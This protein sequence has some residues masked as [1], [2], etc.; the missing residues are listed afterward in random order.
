[1]QADAVGP[2]EDFRLTIKRISDDLD[3]DEVLTLKYLCNDNI[4]NKRLEEIKTG[5]DL[6]DVLCN[7]NLV[8][9]ED[10]K[11]LAECLYTIRRADLLRSH[12][13]LTFSDVKQ[14]MSSSG[15]LLDP[16]RVMI[17][18]VIECMGSSEVKEL[19]FCL[20]EYLPKKYTKY[21]S[22]YTLLM[23]LE[24]CGQL[25]PDNLDMLEH[26]VEKTVEDES[27]LLDIRE[28]KAKRRLMNSQQQVDPTTALKLVIRP[29]EPPLVK[30]IETTSPQKLV[31][32]PPTQPRRVEVQ[33][34]TGAGENGGPLSAGPMQ[35]GQKLGQL[36]FGDDDWVDS[37]CSGACGEAQAEKPGPA[38]AVGGKINLPNDPYHREI[39]EKLPSLQDE[40]GRVTMRKR[41][42]RPREEDCWNIGGAT[43]GHDDIEPSDL[44]KQQEN[45]IS[46]FED[47]TMAT[48]H[49]RDENGKAHLFLP[50]NTHWQPAEP[51]AI[52]TKRDPMLPSF[53]YEPELV[54]SVGTQPG[55]LDLAPPDNEPVVEENE[56]ALPSM[57]DNFHGDEDAHPTEA[58]ELSIHAPPTQSDIPESLEDNNP[59]P[60]L[61]VL[62][63]PVGGEHVGK[64]K[65]EEMELELQKL[66]EEIDKHENDMPSYKIKSDPRGICIIINNVKFH[67]APGGRLLKERHGSDVDQENLRF[68]FSKLKFKI[69]T[70]QN[71]T[72]D[73]IMG[74][75]K[76]A[77]HQTDHSAY[78]CFAFCI[79]THGS[80]GNLFGV[81]GLP[82]D[83]LTI[84]ENFKGLNCP[85]LQGKPKLFF[86][87][88]CQGNTNQIGFRTRIAEDSDNGGETPSLLPNE[89]DFLIGYATLPGFV[90]YRSET[91]G[92]WYI[93][94]L[95]QMLEQ[96]SDRHDLL[97]IMIKV[98]EEVAKASA[99]IEG[100]IYKQ[101]PMPWPTL[102]KKVF[103]KTSD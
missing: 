49:Q 69:Q 64:K 68:I 58:D 35:C 24:R 31:I 83:V 8:T 28:Y 48:G 79:L 22:G 88:A 57:L 16:F 101:S 1:M 93:T 90:S 30:L 99:M 81:G 34:R 9:A 37:T 51:A 21:T 4:P 65:F 60:S 40:A 61:P 39:D 70:Y 84:T 55:E 98:N 27:A 12:L 66:R 53:L 63:I 86:I 7:K 103:L 54:G 92:S 11:Y 67:K 5:L 20:A 56:V 46:S 2:S 72:R 45:D 77:A 100:G 52:Q 91:H 96:H 102:R 62:D 25:G 89:A 26:L 29:T 44:K 78:D 14:L 94:M 47:A 3:S 36:P 59:M 15:P 10:T 76:K 80:K 97:S 41:P 82:V 23:A 71:L 95:V 38:E 33:S 32:E 75:V 19:A 17:M 13:R 50:P 73:D 74:V 85:T 6:F 87:Q 43:G 18:N 42:E